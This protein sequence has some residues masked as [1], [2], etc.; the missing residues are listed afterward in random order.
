MSQLPVKDVIPKSDVEDVR[1][2]TTIERVLRV[3]GD[4]CT[5]IVANLVAV[6]G[7]MILSYVFF[8]DL[9]KYDKYRDN[10]WPVLLTIIGAAVGASFSKRR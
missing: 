4:A 5:K 8:S 7:F 9:P 6:A 3:T 10:A 1:S 2:E